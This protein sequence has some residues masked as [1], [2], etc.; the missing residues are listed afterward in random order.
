MAAA[1]SQTESYTML[2]LESRD[3]FSTAPSLYPPTD[4]VP[5]PAYSTP[6]SDTV[7]FGVTQVPLDSSYDFITRFDYFLSDSI[8]RKSPKWI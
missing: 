2:C 1:V 8:G 6:K 3:G 7:A 4:Y 5:P